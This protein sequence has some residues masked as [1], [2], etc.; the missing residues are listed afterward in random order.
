V[1]RRLGAALAGGEVLLLVGALGTGKTTL[2]QGIAQGLG[3]REYTKSPTFVLVNEY[4][5]RLPLYHVDL[6]RIQGDLEAWELG[7]DEY[8]EGPGVCVVEWADRALRVFPSDHLLVTLER[9]S[10]T[11]RLLRLKAQG[12]RARALLVA[13]GMDSP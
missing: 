11:E 13:A 8:L 6:Y 4:L 12:P 7:L 3:I 2:A 1:G 9:R 5:G 10:D